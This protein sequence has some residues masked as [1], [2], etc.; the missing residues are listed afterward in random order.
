MFLVQLLRNAVRGSAAKIGRSFTASS[1]DL[2]SGFEANSSIIHRVEIFP[3]PTMMNFAHRELLYVLFLSWNFTSRSMGWAGIALA[4]HRH[5]SF[6][7]SFPCFIICIAA[8]LISRESVASL[9]LVVLF[10]SAATVLF[11]FLARALLTGTKTK[12]ED[13]Q[14]VST[15]GW[16]DKGR[17][18]YCQVNVS[19]IR[20]MKSLLIRNIYAKFSRCVILPVLLS[21]QP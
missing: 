5:I 19:C 11:L 1:K 6:N 18:R 14:T 4:R 17:C 13:S 7:V 2:H 10:H 15:P 9:V 3:W 8:A 20:N 21:F 16:P 12:E